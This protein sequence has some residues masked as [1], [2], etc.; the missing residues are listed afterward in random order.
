LAEKEEIE[1]LRKG[2]RFNNWKALVI[3]REAEMSRKQVTKELGLSKASAI[4][5]YEDG[6]EELTKE[7]IA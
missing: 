4:R 1:W 6:R 3:R 7:Y 2:F 5:A